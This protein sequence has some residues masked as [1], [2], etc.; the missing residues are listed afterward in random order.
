VQVVQD[1][2]YSTGRGFLWTEHHCYSVGMLDGHV[3]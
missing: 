2:G 1:G 3:V